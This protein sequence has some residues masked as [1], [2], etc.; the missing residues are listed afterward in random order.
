[1]RRRYVMSEHS[2]P[3]QSRALT[4]L[5]CALSGVIGC[6]AEPEHAPEPTLE[7]RLTKW[8][9]GFEEEV[10]IVKRPDATFVER[11]DGSV[12][13]LYELLEMDRARLRARYGAA[14]RDF[15]ERL[16]RAH[17]DD[18]VEVALH[19]DVPGFEFIAE[20]PIEER[21]G[22]MRAAVVAAAEPLAAELRDIGFEEHGRGSYMP[23]LVGS[24]TR[25]ASTNL[26]QPVA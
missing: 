5:T 20:A 11:A 25:N 26:R 17:D 23:V 8:L 15:H 21:A 18:A 9:P 22:L 2:S 1:M 12:D 13:P 7:Y 14:S 6:G 3:R 16:S 19:Y 24:M 4:I 10:T